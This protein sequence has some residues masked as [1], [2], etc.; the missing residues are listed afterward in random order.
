MASTAPIASNFQLNDGIADGTGIARGDGL[1]GMSAATSEHLGLNVAYEV[2][3][4]GSRQL[5]R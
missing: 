5:D 3:H 4:A 1:E 2:S